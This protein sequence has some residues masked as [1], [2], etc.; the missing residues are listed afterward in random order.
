MTIQRSITTADLNQIRMTSLDIAEITGKRH[1]HVIR[2]IRQEIESIGEIDQPIFGLSEYTD[3]TGRKLPCYEFGR[4]G[5][6]Q[7]SL[8]YDAKTRYMVVKKIDDFE[9]GN[10]KPTTPADLLKEE[11]KIFALFEVPKHL[12]QIESVKQVKKISGVDL[13]YALLVSPAQDNIEKE[14]VMLEPTEL[15]KQFG[16]SGMMM[17]Q[18]LMRMGLQ[19]NDGTGWVPTKRGSEI[20]SKHAWAKGK[21]SGYNL[22]WNE[23]K[24]K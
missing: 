21:K 11:L 8:R 1:A 7:I 24:I 13:S 16:L 10:L 4:A 17:N 2:D 23:S 22:K 12:A 18:K 19:F 5:A 20:S 9:S 6:M 3:S 14:S 15:G